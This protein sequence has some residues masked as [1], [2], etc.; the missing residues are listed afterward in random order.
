MVIFSLLQFEHEHLP[1]TITNH[2]DIRRLSDL[3]ITIEPELE[4]EVSETEDAM[5]EQGMF[6]YDD[7]RSS[8]SSDSE[9]LRNWMDENLLRSNIGS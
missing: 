5:E 2:S 7:T 8:Q 9:I 1:H 6:A 3:N 4:S